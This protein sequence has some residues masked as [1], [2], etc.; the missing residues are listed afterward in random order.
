MSRSYKQCVNQEMFE[1]L[2]MPYRSDNTVV[3]ELFAFG[4]CLDAQ[5]QLQEQVDG[6]QKI[7]NVLAQPL[8]H[9]RSFEQVSEMPN[10]ESTG[11]VVPLTVRHEQLIKLA[12]KLVLDV[13]EV[14]RNMM[15]GNDH[16]VE[17][18]DSVVSE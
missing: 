2:R 6:V 10:K 9:R 12:D 3:R 4:E 1:Q 13:V 16:A 5:Q 15:L 8:V 14:L 11:Y 18:L 17:D 7:R